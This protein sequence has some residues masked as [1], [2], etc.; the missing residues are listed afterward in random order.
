MYNMIAFANMTA[1]LAAPAG[2]P[3]PPFWQSLVLELLKNPG[4][5]W[6]IFVS[7]LLKLFYKPLRHDLLPNLSGFKVMGV[8][9]SFVQASITQAIK[10]AEKSKEFPGVEISDADQQRVLNRVRKNAGLF[11]GRRILW[12]DDF[13][14][15]PTNERE[16]LQSLLVNVEMAASTAEAEKLLKDKKYDLILSDMKRG[17]D[18]TAG[19]KFLQDYARQE[20]RVPVIFYIGHSD[21]SKGVP[22][23]AF[24]ITHRPDEL[25]HLIMDALERV[26]S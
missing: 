24:G 21:P 9:F 15:S 25:L 17:D 11:R 18:N 8:E 1:K 10:L 2:D 12:I 3:P 16:M 22:P 14:D 13:P 5:F 4:I 26:K 23:H 19:I 6:L 7:I 20:K